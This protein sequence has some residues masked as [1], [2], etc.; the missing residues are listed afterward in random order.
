MAQINFVLSQSADFDVANTNPS[1]LNDAAAQ[2]ITTSLAYAGY[3]ERNPLY[4]HL[5][6]FLHSAIP[7]YFAEDVGVTRSSTF[8]FM[9]VQILVNV[10]ITR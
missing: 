4:P 7:V 1:V 3:T 8:S 6:R 2:R 5:Y 10:T 9:G